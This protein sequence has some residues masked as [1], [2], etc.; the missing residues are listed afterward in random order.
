VYHTAD[1][2]A[3]TTLYLTPC[4]GNRIDLPDS[5]GNPQRHTTAEISI[6]VPATTSQMYD[7]FVYSSSGTA[8]LELLAW[9]NDTT[10]ATALVRTNGR[11]LKTGD[12]TRMYVGSV[13]TTTVSG[14][15][16]DSAV[17]RYV[18]NM[19]NRAERVLQRLETTASWTYQTATFRQANAAAANQ[20]DVV[21][22]LAESPLWLQLTVTAAQFGR[23]RRGRPYQHGHRRGFHDNGRLVGGRAD[24]HL[25]GRVDGF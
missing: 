19:Y 10:R 21:Q 16:E 9:T 8:T 3:A 24:Q 17:K 6:A 13:R 22:G 18:W 2:T 12:L 14:Q 11:W 4:Y 1:V 5:L 15:T 7:V 20:V 25:Y 23:R